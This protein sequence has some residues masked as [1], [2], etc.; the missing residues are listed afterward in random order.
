MRRAGSCCWGLEGRYRW[1]SSTDRDV[2]FRDVLGLAGTSAVNDS[3]QFDAGVNI[4]FAG[5]VVDVNVFT[6]VTVR[7]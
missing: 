1:Q 7:F 5:E 3:L 4:G 6:G 2:G